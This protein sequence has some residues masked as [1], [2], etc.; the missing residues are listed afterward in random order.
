M[1][2]RCVVISC[3][4][5]LNSACSQAVACTSLGSSSGIFA[6]LDL[7]IVGSFA[8][9]RCWL[10]SAFELCL[11]VDLW[12]GSGPVSDEYQCPFLK[13]LKLMTVGY[14]FETFLTII[15]FNIFLK[16]FIDFFELFGCR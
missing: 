7:V 10:L 16:V 14:C 4:Y 3:F 8:R 1:S 12:S 6:G 15:V 9:M 5:G 13:K 2:F 11:F